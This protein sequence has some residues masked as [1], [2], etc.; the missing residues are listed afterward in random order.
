MGAIA[1][2]IVNFARP[3]I[4]ATDGS[5]EQLNRAMALGQLCWTLAMLP[6]DS[7]EELLTK[8]RPELKMDDDEFEEFRQTVVLPMI[9]RHE[10]MFPLMHGR[11]LMESSGDSTDFLREPEPE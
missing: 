6:E 11:S 7:R 9:R 10:E 5:H 1:D 4:D 2:G 8:M 3:L